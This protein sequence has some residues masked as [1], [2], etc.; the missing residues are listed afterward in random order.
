MHTFKKSKIEKTKKDR[1]IID[2]KLHV[3]SDF[4]FDSFW[5]VFD[6]F[7]EAKNLDFRTFGKVFGKVREERRKEKKRRKKE[8]EEREGTLNYQIL[9][10][11]ATCIRGDISRLLLRLLLLRA[12]FCASWNGPGS[13]LEAPGPE[14]GA[15]FGVAGRLFFDVFAC[16]RAFA[17]RWL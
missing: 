11:S 10:F 4:D 13:I 6:K 15:C 3:F 14:S 8:R 1:T 17:V 7:W 16:V 2:E 5:K 12:G 9:L